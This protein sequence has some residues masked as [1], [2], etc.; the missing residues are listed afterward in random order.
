MDFRRIEISCGKDDIN[1]VEKLDGADAIVHWHEDHI[2]EGRKEIIMLVRGG[3]RQTLL[4][5][6]EEKLQH[7]DDWRVLVLPVDGVLP[8]PDEEDTKAD[9]EAE[10]QR[11][12]RE[13]IFN[14]VRSGAGLSTDIM[15]LLAASAIVAS[16]GIL[17]DTIAV[18]IGAMLIAPM[19]GPILSLVLGNALGERWLIFNSLIASVSGIA[20]AFG[21]GAI[22][23]FLFEA[24][25]SGVQIASAVQVGF[26]DIVLAIASGVAAALSVTSRQVTI[27][28]GVMVAAALLPPIVTSG[29]LFG[30][31]HFGLSG[32]AMLL[33]L[34]NI[35]GINL[36]GQL[37]FLWKGIRPRTWYEQKQ[38][39]QSLL[40]TMGILVASLVALTA[41]I[42]FL[43]EPK[44]G[45]DN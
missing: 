4:D 28:V 10:D 14:Q 36:A 11:L 30:G 45:T 17:T 43:G 21:V 39:T 7:T 19:L 15:L 34:T 41:A 13:E 22:T 29:I 35:V 38:A 9:E 32:R 5:S 24:K 42:Y 16:G 31:G 33:G 26:E 44:L 1:D 3:G 37:V 8:L 25:P 23:G 27:M 2:Q 18:T 40:I 6:I 12:S 20:I